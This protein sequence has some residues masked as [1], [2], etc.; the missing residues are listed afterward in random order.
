MKDYGMA[1]G[2]DL[3]HLRSR[4]RNFQLSI[5]NFPFLRF[6]FLK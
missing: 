5:F 3:N 6:Y 1:F 4:Y 2:H